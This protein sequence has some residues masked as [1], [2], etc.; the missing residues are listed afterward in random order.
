MLLADFNSILIWIIFFNRHKTLPAMRKFMLFSLSVLCAISL[1]AQQRAITGK[2]SDADGKP[3][4][5]ASIVVKGTSTGTT[6]AQD[7][8]FKLNVAA[9]AKTLVVSSLNY[10]SQEISIGSQSV[11]NVSLKASTEK[12]DEVVVVAYGTQKKEAFTGSISTVKSDLIAERP[13]TSIEKALQGAAAGVTVQSVSGQPGGATQVRIRGVGSFNAS[14]TP[15]YVVDGIAITTG[16]FTQ[17]STTADVLATLNPDDVESISVLKDASAASL[18]GSRAGNGVVLITTKKG[19]SG[20]AKMNFAANYGLSSIAVNK[21]DVMTGDQYFKYWWD[22]YYSARV[23]AGDAPAVAATKAN[24]STIT[25]LGVNPYNNVNPYNENGTLNSGVAALYQ[26]NWRDAV[27]RQGTSA[28]YNL[29]V[30]G[31]NDRTTYYI[32]GGYM[33]QKGIT[34]ASDFKRYSAKINVETKATDYFKLGVNTTLAYTDQNTPPGAGGAANPIRFADIVS[35]VY[36]LYRLDA[37]GAPIPDPNGGYLYNYRTPVVFDYNP[38]GLAIKNIYNAKTTRAII[39]AFAEVSIMQ[40]LKFRSQGAIDLVDIRETQY[41]NPVNG[42]GSGVKGRTGKYTPRNLVLTMTNTLT[43]DKKFGEHSLSLLLG[44]EAVKTRYENVY[45]TGTTFPFDGIVELASAATPVSAYSSLD[46]RRLSSY[47]SRLNYNFKNRY[48]LSGSFRR[49]GSSVFGLNSRYGNF[50][51]VGGAWRLSEEDFMKGI[52][53]TW[54]TD[55]KLRASYG[56]SGND[57]IGSYDRLGLY[58]TG[59]NYGGASGTIYTQLANPDLKWEGNTVTDIGIEFSLFKKVRAEVAYFNRGSQ[60]ILFNKPLSYT[61]G[62]GS[63][64][65]NLATM[66]NSGVE[67]LVEVNAINKKSFSWDISLNLTSYRN[68]IQKMTVDSLIQGSQIWRVGKD[69]YQWFMRDYV[70]VDPDDGRPM[71]YQDEM[72]GGVATGKKITTKDWNAASRYYLGSALPKFT[73][74]LTNRFKFGQFDAMVFI[75]FSYGGKIYDGSLA[76]QMH[77]GASRGQQLAV[78][79]YAAWQKK[80]DITDVPRF[81]DRNTDLGNNTS[82]RFLYDGSYIRLKTL[83]IGYSLSKALVDKFKISSARFYI[84][85]ENILNFAKHKGMDPETSI[86]GTNNND[87]PNVKTIAFGL[88][89]GF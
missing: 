46:E 20:R 82:T 1:F 48:F 3:I 44:Q 73:G 64:S 22:S 45:A 70:G 68:Q 71:W 52:S 51:S 85:A 88:N 53:G 47:F 38:V 50:W 84:S 83:N 23:A 17:V 62:F 63:I 11:F 30:Q 9:T 57:R 39:N 24:A 80:G 37:T 40:G 86:D 89:I 16:D 43:Y 21:Y 59:Y 35:N 19:R 60:D 2:I 66:K 56:K 34:L 12:L 25:A 72:V 26:T 27:T 78:Q 4:P 29:S 33:D 14:N 42:D 31:G 49:D 7:G 81:V 74:G 79:S 15:L 76:S 13:V 8:S 10:A 61:T 5:N 6:S 54:L 18:Y 32:S 36:P 69:R 58:G 28:D 55:L 41:Y 65:T 67:A 75:F 87:V 77:G